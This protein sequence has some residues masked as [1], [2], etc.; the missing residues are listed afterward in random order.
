MR[1]FR[2]RRPSSVAEAVSA[3]AAAADG[4][5]IAGGMTLIPIIKQR[6]AQP[7]DI[8]DLGGI[9]GLDAIAIDGASLVFGALV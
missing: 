8:I 7:S 3:L 6:L 1:A 5:V 2:Y 9:G 4:K